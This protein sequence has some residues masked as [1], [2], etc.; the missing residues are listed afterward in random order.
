MKGCKFTASSGF[1][2]TL[3]VWFVLLRVEVEVIRVG[4][5]G[6]TGYTGV[7]LLRLLA[8]HPQAEVVCITSRAND[9][10][11]VAQMFPN[12]RGHY[13]LAFSAPSS[14]VISQC[15]V[16]FFATPH[17]VAQSM[18]KDVIGAGVKVIDLSADFRIRDIALW[19]QWYNQPHQCPEL[20]SEAVY[21]LP[22]VNREQIKSAQLVACPGCY[23]TSVQLG[24][25]PLLEA[26][27]VDAKRLIANA[28][29]G[30][31]GAGRQANVDTS[32][33]EASDSFKAYGASGH[34]H[35][36]E[37]E[38]GL[39]DIQAGKGEAAQVTFVPHLLPM[40]RG[41][42]ATLYATLIDKD[43]DLQALY[44]QRYGNEPFV[45]VLPVGMLPQTRSVKG[46]NI[47]RIAVLKP[48]QR[49]TAV[50]LVAEDNLTKGA[51]GQAVQNMN[52]MFGL[53][54]TLGLNFPALLP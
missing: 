1:L 45:D 6:G 15:D 35:L 30:V 34:R 49:D 43:I 47:A 22:E 19:E 13:D 31:S 3:C 42:H 36:P 18:M 8:H 14:E 11:A 37:I 2:F 33:A 5:V 28:A 23:P 9:G 53:E 20:V 26:G 17:G 41:I 52:I 44:E 50:I 12:L 21:G 39:S 54:E 38:Q 46:T 40:I 16:V 24:F 27:L 7:E 51:S 29:S 10:M 25:M 32:L 48:Q 4:I